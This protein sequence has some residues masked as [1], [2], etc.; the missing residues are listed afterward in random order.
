MIAGECDDPWA[1]VSKCIAVVVY[2]P[3][4][5]QSPRSEDGAGSFA[6]LTPATNEK[7]RE[8]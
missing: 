4:R 2:E 8:S 6:S 7:P 3:L 1:A 5:D